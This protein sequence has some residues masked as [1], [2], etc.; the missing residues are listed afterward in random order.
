MMQ[1]VFS[2][3]L[4]LA[5][6]CQGLN[7]FPEGL[8]MISNITVP[9]AAY[10]HLV[11]FEDDRSPSLFVTSFGFNPFNNPDKVAYWADAR[12]ATLG[13]ETPRPQR[14]VGDVTW[15]NYVVQ[16]PRSVF[17]MDGIV[18]AGGFLV[19][20]KTNGGIWFSA[21]WFIGSNP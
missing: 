5:G 16:A 19:P 20:T 4:A 2:I 3:V 13:S 15:P 6:S 8:R 14:I 17:G 18:V 1:I 10:C 12:F 7:S 9:N 21:R 11:P